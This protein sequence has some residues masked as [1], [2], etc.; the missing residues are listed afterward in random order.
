MKTA[1]MVLIALLTLG[2]VHIA[3][4]AAPPIHVL[5]LTGQNNH[6][7]KATT[8]VLKS[9]LEDTGRFKVDVTTDP[10]RADLGTFRRYQ[11]LITNYNG[12]RW[13]EKT[14]K[15]LLEYVRNGGGFVVIHAANNAF[16][17][18]PEYDRLIGGAWR[19][20][21]GH[22]K[23]HSFRVVFV[24]RSHPITARMP[25]FLGAQD[26]LYH[27]MTMQPD[28][29]VLATAY[30]APDQGGTGRDEPIAWVVNYG[31][32]RVFQNVQ[33]HGA[34]AMRATGYALLLRR[35]TE[36]VATGRVA[37]SV[38]LAEAAV[39]AVGE[40]QG[41]FRYEA[42]NR[43][44][45]MADRAVPALFDA[46]GRNDTLCA[47]DARDALL[48]I[49]Q[50]WADSPSSRARVSQA[51]MSFAAPGRRDEVRLLAVRLLGIIGRDEAVPLLVSALKDSA[52]SAEAVQSL[53]L[54]PGP[55]AAKALL[56]VL[57]QA[58]E[59]DAVRIIHALGQRRDPALPDAFRALT[60]A[61]RDK[62]PAV[63][64]EAIRALAKFQDVALL[65]LFQGL[66]K[67]GPADVRE[68]ALDAEL[69]IADWCRQAGRS[70]QA[71]L[72][73]EHVLA[74][75]QTEPQRLAAIAGLGM[76]GVAASVKPILPY[77]NDP[78]RPR[79]QAAAVAA[80]RSI[81][82]PEA[83]QALLGAYESVA[84]PVGVAILSA[85][86]Q[87]RDAA[88][89]PVL[90]GATKSGNEDVQMAAIRALG[91]IGSAQGLPVLR[92]AMS[93][94]AQ[95][96][97]SAA[98]NSA[99]K[100]ADALATSGQ[101]AAKAEA[102]QVYS[103]AFDAALTSGQ[104]AAA[105]NG[106]AR[107]ASAQAV[108]KIES[109]VGSSTGPARD[110]ALDA[111][112]AAADRL[113]AANAQE[114]RRLCA[115]ALD[116]LP[117]GPRSVAVAQKLKALGADIDL[118][119]VQG[120][121]TNWWIIGPFP[122]VNGSAAYDIAYFPEKEIALDKSYEIEGR[123]LKWRFHHTDD[124]NG[125]VDLLALIEPNENMAAYAYAEVT[126]PGV[127]DGMV[128]TGSDDGIVVWVNGQRVQGV[129]RARGLAV[130]EDSAPMH[131]VQGVNKIL[132]KVL[133]GGADFEFCL[134]LVDSDRNPLRLESKRP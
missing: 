80:L 42:K 83:T 52:V 55:A 20:N 4:A 30:S 3:W 45:L 73:Y 10:A 48:W 117:A 116:L 72:A 93:G 15:A 31:K 104:R 90:A 64:I 110:A 91:E 38:S 43:L 67:E 29:H 124:L 8:P 57:P 123:P 96:V 40:A 112:L 5:I 100:I 84:P 54:I 113:S 77:L 35:G 121:V 39:L 101:D 46:V 127:R 120:F 99:I 49:A 24:D 74:N 47:D 92:A 32:G 94:Q 21:A 86:G 56:R 82:G 58:S 103:E 85:F 18:W 131:L 79:L 119:A 41:D 14:E 118:A 134:R 126:S 69:S 87:R 122:N 28:A 50:R 81:P 13:G 114:A 102:T 65:D 133:N 63:R 78:S 59:Q 33:G 88:A 128:L 60:A 2:V 132:V 23:Q 61:V 115:K 22:G 1:R 26:E 71:V 66:A 76:V 25:D 6:D 53:T 89:V 44:I 11:A 95:A 12:P 75:A 125:V 37:K 62:R 9:I 109:V 16:P 70:A 34:E 19:A 107:V 36:W 106:L 105:L 27:R 68:A 111:L 17:D 97:K 98:V 51:I 108:A 7:W 129:N 130:D